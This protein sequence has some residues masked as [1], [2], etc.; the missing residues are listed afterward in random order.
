[1]KG[2]KRAKSIPERKSG[3]FFIPKLL[4]HG[5]KN[6]PLKP[7]R[8]KFRYCNWPLCLSVKTKAANDS[9]ASLSPISD[10]ST[11]FAGKD[12]THMDFPFCILY[13]CSY[14]S[15]HSPFVFNLNTTEFADQKAP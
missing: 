4:L 7:H 6:I 13:P 5:Q 11:F 10:V 14:V 15:I 1:M 8:D 12:L 3:P 9:A 2:V